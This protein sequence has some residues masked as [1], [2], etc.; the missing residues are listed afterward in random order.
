MTPATQEEIQ[1]G[2]WCLEDTSRVLFQEAWPCSWRQ[3]QIILLENIIN[4]LKSIEG[5]VYTNFVLHL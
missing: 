5:L 2:I 4:T 1:T 3:T